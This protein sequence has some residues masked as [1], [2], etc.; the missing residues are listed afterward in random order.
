[1]REHVASHGDAGSVARR[2][3]QGCQ[4]LQ[5][6][7]Q[8]CPGPDRRV[9]HRKAREARGPDGPGRCLA[10]IDPP[11]RR[12]AREPEPGD[13]CCLEGRPHHLSHQRRG[14]VIAAARAALGGIHHPLEHPAEHIGC[15]EIGVLGLAHREVEPL[16]QRVEGV[17]PVD[18]APIGGPVAALQRRGLE[19]AAVQERHPAQRAGAGRALGR[20][21]VERTETQRVQDLAMKGA[22]GGQR[23]VEA[24]DDVASVSVQPPFR[25]DEIQKQHARQR[26]EGEGVA[27]GAAAGRGEPVGEPLEDRTERLEEPGGDALACERLADSQAQRERSLTGSGSEPLEG[28]ERAPRRTLE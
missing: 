28:A 7:E 20:S 16:E 27:L 13:E 4:L 18:V 12:A 17:A 21:P 1:M 15:D 5:R 10:V 2:L 9:E 22:A 23:G 19:Q 26:A 11:L 3:A 8:E 24:V 14:S 25:L 6:A